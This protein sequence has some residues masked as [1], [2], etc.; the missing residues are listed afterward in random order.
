[1]DHPL[2]T[3]TC[4]AL[5]TPF[6]DN[7][8][9]YSMLEKI[10]QFQ[11]DSGI[12]TIVLCGTTGESPTLS[13]KEKISIFRHAKQY[14]GDNCTI[15]AGT[16]SNSTQH[17]IELSCAAQDAGADGL[18]IV[19]PYY[20]KSNADGLYRH[21]TTIA[22]ETNLPIIL[23][24]VP[25]R[26][27]VDIPISV[28]QALTNI[29]NIAGVKEAS[30]D[31]TKIVKIRATCPDDFCIWSGNDD[32]IVPVMSLGGKGVIS[33]LSNIFPKETQLMTQC[34]LSQDYKTASNMQC[35][36]LPFIELLFREVNP[37]PVKYAISKIGFDCG[38]CRL[39]LGDLCAETKAA[40][41]VYF[42]K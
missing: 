25:T 37:I 8:V 11:I 41:D 17:A 5:V 10:L 34:A 19:S 42:A 22:Q 6:I 13:D 9:N 39:P 40:I 14:C 31:I 24:N 26:T 4:T 21:F 32:Q 38:S 27:G 23:Y 15:I 16:G 35:K 33:V 36:L 12:H 28:Y 3:G 7:Q 20:N 29:P 2:F 1:M 18:L 30:S